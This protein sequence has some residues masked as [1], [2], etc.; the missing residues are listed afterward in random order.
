MKLFTHLHV[1][2]C[3]PE[4]ESH[5]LFG[6]S[7]SFHTLPSRHRQG[8]S[9][10]LPLIGSGT[11]RSRYLEQVGL[12][13]VRSSSSVVYQGISVD[14]PAVDQVGCAIALSTR[15]VRVILQR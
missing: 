9:A 12:L 3:L 10:S 13:Q 5:R 8:S 6:K 4:P 2:T 15:A 11:D 7:Y 14:T 1:T